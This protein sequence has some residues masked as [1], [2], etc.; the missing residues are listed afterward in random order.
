MFEGLTQNTFDEESW[1]AV[2]SWQKAVGKGCSYR[3]H[4]NLL[5]LQKFKVRVNIEK[6]LVPHSAG[7]AYYIAENLRRQ[8]NIQIIYAQ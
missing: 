6:K 2:G 7:A 3:G 4:K 5:E 1:K 8:G